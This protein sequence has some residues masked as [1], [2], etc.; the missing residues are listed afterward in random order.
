MLSYTSKLSD[1]YIADFEFLKI[2]QEIFSLQ[3]E[4]AAT[5][6]NK[7]N[8]YVGFEMTIIKVYVKNKPSVVSTA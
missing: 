5:M 3:F 1:Q 6:T 2:N 7:A 8:V 4:I